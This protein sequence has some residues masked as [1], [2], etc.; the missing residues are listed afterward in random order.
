MLSPDA[1]RRQHDLKIVFT[2]LHGTTYKL[3][4]DSLRHWGF[5]NITT[6]PEQMVTDGDFPTVASANPEEPAAF[7]WHSTKRAK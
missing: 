7:K 4:P 6:V 5:T 3:V 1:V 2:P